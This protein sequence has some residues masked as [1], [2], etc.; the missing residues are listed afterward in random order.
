MAQQG[1]SLQAQTLE[2]V[3]CEECLKSAAVLLPPVGLVPTPSPRP[4][5]TTAGE[6]ALQLPPPSPPL[7]R[8]PTR[9]LECASRPS[10]DCAPTPPHP[11]THHTH[12]P[13]KTGLED[14]QEQRA[15]LLV[16]AREE[17]AERARLQQ[18]AAVLQRRLGQLEASLERR[19][20]GRE[21][22]DRVIEQSQGALSKLVESSSML[23][24][25]TKR[26]AQEV[27]GPCCGGAGWQHQLLHV[28]LW[29]AGATQSLMS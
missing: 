15:A 20:A 9:P 29:A 27:G 12:T 13:T 17:E 7:C 22:L 3:K 19:A 1:A 23:L 26:N 5:A 10:H 16:A 28:P 18:D 6:R 2:L 8:L 11:P 24:Q 14:L 25:V 21:A 4:P